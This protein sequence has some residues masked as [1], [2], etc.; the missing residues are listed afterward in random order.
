MSNGGVIGASNAATA[1]AAPGVWNI[2]DVYNARLTGDWPALAIQD[3][4]LIEFVMFNAVG[5][6]QGTVFEDVNFVHPVG[7]TE[8]RFTV[9]S[10]TDTFTITTASFPE[11]HLLSVDDE[12]FFVAATATDLPPPILPDTPYYIESVPTT[13]TFKVSETIGGAAVSLISNGT[14]NADRKIFKRPGPSDPSLDIEIFH[15]DAATFPSGLTIDSLQSVGENIDADFRLTCVVVDKDLTIDTGGTLQIINNRRRF[16]FMIASRE[17]VQIGPGTWTIPHFQ[18]ITPPGPQQRGH[19]QFRRWSISNRLPFATGFLVAGGNGGS[20]IPGLAPNG[21][22]QSAGGG[23]GSAFGGLGGSAAGAQFGGNPGR[24]TK[25]GDAGPGP[26][27]PN[28]YSFTPVGTGFAGAG[29]TYGLK[30]V[31]PSPVNPSALDLLRNFAVV[32][33][34]N[35]TL[36]GPHPV[37]NIDVGGFKT[38]SFP[39]PSFTQ[40]QNGGSTGGGNVYIIHAGTYTN[41]GSINVAGGTANAPLGGAGG[42]GNVIIEPVLGV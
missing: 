40:R 9:N 42:T 33:G 17:N 27:S 19:P 7:N 36:P 26:Q 35:V 20:K 10:A 32:V 24:G 30:G 2:Q 39:L 21:G 13:T 11:G 15:Y 18:N 23:G 22:N 12:V 25:G 1:L 41:D 6:I 5:G 4:G 34:N 29:N 14:E 38:R 28:P 16:G 3:P 31:S 8:G 37:A